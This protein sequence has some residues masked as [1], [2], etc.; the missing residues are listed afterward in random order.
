MPEERERGYYWILYD[1][2]SAWEIGY[3]G[4]GKWSLCGEDVDF[5]DEDFDEISEKRISVDSK[6]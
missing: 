1:E 2:N 4:N 6:Q 3:Y 5:D